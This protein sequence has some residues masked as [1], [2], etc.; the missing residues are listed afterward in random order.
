MKYRWVDGT[1]HHIL[2]VNGGYKALVSMHA[3]YVV[4]LLN[5][6]QYGWDRQET[7]Y[8]SKAEA[9]AVA[10]ALVAMR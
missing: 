10:V 4:S 6:K 9:E 1:A 5:P 8:T 2:V 3:P 7:V